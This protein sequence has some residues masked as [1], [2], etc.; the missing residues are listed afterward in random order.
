MDSATSMAV[1]AHVLSPAG[2]EEKKK[3]KTEEKKKKK[4]EKRKIF[5]W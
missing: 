5:Q 4:D 2:K 1:V 3:E